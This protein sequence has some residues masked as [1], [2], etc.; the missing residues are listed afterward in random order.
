[1]FPYLK[2]YNKI[3]DRVQKSFPA[4][5]N[6]E[7]DLNIEEIENTKPNPEPNDVEPTFEN[8]N[9]SDTNSSDNSLEHEHIQSDA[10]NNCSIKKNIPLHI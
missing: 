5:Q 9:S 1:M 2:H 4:S 3:N 7:D 8:T 6:Y 10:R